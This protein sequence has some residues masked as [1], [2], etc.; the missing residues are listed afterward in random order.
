MIMILA[1]WLTIVIGIVVS[2]FSFVGFGFL[3]GMFVLLGF[4]VLLNGFLVGA[5][6]QKSKAL[7]ACNARRYGIVRE[8]QTTGDFRVLKDIVD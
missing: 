8:W 1:A 3:V 7:N 4:V 2:S 5:I 6:Y